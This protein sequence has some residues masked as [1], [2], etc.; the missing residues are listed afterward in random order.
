MVVSALNLPRSFLVASRFVLSISM[1]VKNERIEHERRKGE[2]ASINPARRNPIGGKSA[3][4]S[5][6]IAAAAVVRSNA[7]RGNETVHDSFRNTTT[8][9]LIRVTVV[10][11]FVFPVP[12]M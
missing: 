2:K 4:T 7:K 5:V 3:S 11:I 1:Q 12:R 8:E 9:D 6:A 10:V